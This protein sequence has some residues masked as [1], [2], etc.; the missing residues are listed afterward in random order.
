MSA[1]AK[2]LFDLDFAA[3]PP[4]PEKVESEP[5]IAVKEHQSA[6]TAAQA[7]GY[8]NGFAA[9]QAE[10]RAEEA[11]RSAAALER[12]ATGI[13]TLARA[14]GGVE[15]RLECEAVEVAVAVGRKLAPAL[16]AREPFAEIAQLAAD[17]FTHLV[18]APHVAIRI[19]DQLYAEMREQLEET[20]RTRGFEGRLVILAD[21]QIRPGDCRIE[22]ADGGVVRD[23]NAIDAAV[24]DAV[25]RYL[26]VRQP[27]IPAD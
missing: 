12:I 26:A 4:P 13:E 22:W 19:N 14:M 23:R 20:A 17:C 1:R 6:L 25:N 9:A 21:P 7:E 16:I 15:A 24:G 5:T 11:R 2:F 3:P 10:A 27:A 8:R 18:A